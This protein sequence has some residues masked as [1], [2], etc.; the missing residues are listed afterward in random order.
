M[1]NKCAGKYKNG[2]NCRSNGKFLVGDKY[3]CGIHNKQEST[4]NDI[5][6]L[7]DALVPV[8]PVPENDDKCEKVNV[9]GNRCKNKARHEIDGK[10][11]CSIHSRRNHMC[12][13]IFR[14]RRCPRNAH[15]EVDGHYFCRQHNPRPIEVV[16]NEDEDGGIVVSSDRNLEND[17][18]FRRLIHTIM[19]Q[20]QR[21]RITPEI[22][23][24]RTFP[25]KIKTIN[26]NDKLCTICQEEYK[27]D[28]DARRL[29]CLHF[30]HKDCVDPW[31]LNNSHK[32][33]LCK[34]SIL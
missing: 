6:P 13:H 34:I 2:N 1:S 14:E 17:E 19:S 26:D 20:R 4:I 12:E 32:C 8:D 22:L 30:Y 27:K 31:L 21:P 9:G 11:Y 15:I 33:P 10:R 29:P 23:D 7:I 16:I 18:E 28:E 24:N 25:F 5:P 3:F